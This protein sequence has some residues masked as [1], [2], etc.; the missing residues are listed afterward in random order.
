[1]LSRMAGILKNCG[2]VGGID[3]TV[4][5]TPPKLWVLCEVPPL[6]KTGESGPKLAEWCGE[7]G[8]CGGNIKCYECTPYVI[9]VCKRDSTESKLEL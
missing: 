7:T 4:W 6:S 1:M 3:F 5:C 9:C 8:S 2:G